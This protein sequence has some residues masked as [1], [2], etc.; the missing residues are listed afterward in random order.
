M[1]IA[2]V[3]FVQLQ[4][5]QVRGI[6]GTGLGH[7]ERIIA[8][9]PFRDYATFGSQAAARIMSEGLDKPITPTRA[10]QVLSDMVK[11]N[12]LIKVTAT[13]WQRANQENSYN[14]KPFRT[15][16]FEWEGQHSPAWY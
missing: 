8:S 9:R 1:L 3:S 11:R 6:K 14:R 16:F 4:A 2:K 10:C 12:V 7:Q 15:Q 5:L 13:Q